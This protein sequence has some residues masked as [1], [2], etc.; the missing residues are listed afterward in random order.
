MGRSKFRRSQDRGEIK[1]YGPAPQRAGK[2]DGARGQM[3]FSLP[4]PDGRAG[5]ERQGRRRVRRRAFQAIFGVLRA[6]LAGPETT[7]SEF[8]ALHVRERRQHAL[9]VLPMP[10]TRPRPVAGVPRRA[11]A[12]RVVHAEPG[13]G[14]EPQQT[15]GPLEVRRRP[16]EVVAEVRLGPRCHASR[17][18]ALC[19]GR[20]QD[21][22]RRQVRRQQ[23]PRRR[24]G[25]S[26]P[27]VLGGDSIDTTPSQATTARPS[28]RSTP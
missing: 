23:L 20:Y 8:R 28:G 7:Q 27:G 5:R 24:Q 25:R 10:R 17:E 9:G 26:T 22:D 1:R 21:T 18:A 16:H 15:T 13:R 3:L 14:A 19:A 6:R 12:T 4:R 11:A 2:R